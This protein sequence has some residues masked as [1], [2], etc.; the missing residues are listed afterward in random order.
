MFT[1]IRY[2][3][4]SKHFRAVPSEDAKAFAQKHRLSFIETSALDSTNV[5]DAFHQVWPLSFE[6]LCF[7]DKKLLIWLGLCKKEMLAKPAIHQVINKIY[8]NQSKKQHLSDSG[9]GGG[10]SLLRGRTLSRRR[11]S[12]LSSKSCCSW[13]PQFNITHGHW[14]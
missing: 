7:F 3:Y 2:L 10:R 4:M 14:I 6:F 5:E 9:E 12:N 13:W 8:S 11:Q 1:K